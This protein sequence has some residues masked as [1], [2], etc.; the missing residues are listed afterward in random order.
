MCMCTFYVCNNNELY[1]YAFYVCN[2]NKLYVCIHPTLVTMMDYKY[3]Y[4]LLCT[5]HVVTTVR[6]TMIIQLRMT[7]IILIENDNDYFN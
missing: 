6:M 4:T 2:D 5:L 1:V 7:T 3:I